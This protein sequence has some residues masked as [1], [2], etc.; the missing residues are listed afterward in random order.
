MVRTAPAETPAS[1]TSA[2]R[3]VA[4]E[5]LPC[6]PDL[7]HF[8]PLLNRQLGI[9]RRNGRRLST[10]LIEADPETGSGAGQLPHQ[11]PLLLQAFGARLRSR[12]RASDAVCRIGDQRFGVVL[13]GAGRPEADVVLKRLQ[14]LLWGPYSIDGQRLSLTLHTGVAIHGESGM[15]G[16]ELTTAAAGELG[17][18]L[19]D[20]PGRPRTAEAAVDF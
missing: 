20:V 2:Q 1:D 11:R 17:L 14:Q 12:V 3:P 7:E 18:I 19:A 13:I 15:T 6:L 5:A 9:C 8:V 10:L 4:S 16:L